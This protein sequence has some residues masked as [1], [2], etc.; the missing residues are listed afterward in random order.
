MGLGKRPVLARADAH[1]PV[2]AGGSGSCCFREMRINNPIVNF[3]VLGERNL[4][5]CCIII[6][7][8]Y[9][10]LYAATISLPSLLQ[11]LFG[12]DALASGLVL[13][14]GGI[15]SISALVAVGFLLSRG[16]DAPL[17]NRGRPDCD[18]SRK[19]LD[20]LHE[21]RDQPLAGVVGPRMVLTGGLGLIF[22]PMSVAAFM[23]TPK[24]LRGAAVGLLALL[25]NEGGSVGTSMAQTIQGAP[26]AVPHVRGVGEFLD[27]LNP[28]VNSLPGAGSEPSSSS[29]PVMQRRRVRWLCKRWRTSA[30][31]RRCRWP[32]STSSGWRR[33]WV[34]RLV[35]LVLLMK[36][37]GARERSPSV[38]RVISADG[39]K[40][41]ARY[42]CLCRA[43]SCLL[44]PGLPLALPDVRQA[45]EAE[46]VSLGAFLRP[47]AGSVV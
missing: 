13:S 6:F 14:P 43:Q 7:C 18:V 27:P 4:A 15:T 29:K 11:T 24:H 22:A 31:S 9:A 42:L 45:G 33:S 36:R 2:R 44:I 3:R 25:R 40:T 38:R 30:S 39:A 8:A 37:S 10:A 26:R 1:D 20:G 46:H 16:I 28:I 17:V 5:V 32:T 23:Y 47:I 12:Y 21:P 34:W 19:S 35:V 41:M